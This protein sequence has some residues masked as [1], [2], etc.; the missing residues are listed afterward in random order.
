MITYL[1]LEDR[2]VTH[3]LKNV[4]G[5]LGVQTGSPEILSPSASAYLMKSNA[6]VC[7]TR[8]LDLILVSTMIS[9]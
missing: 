7:S 8:R 9:R 6:T 4:L 2:A 3:D 5:V 1:T